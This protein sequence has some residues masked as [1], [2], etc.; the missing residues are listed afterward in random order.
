MKIEEE[1]ELKMENSA[2]VIR[3]QASFAER[4]DLPGEGA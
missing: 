3:W 1:Y 2:A 4:S